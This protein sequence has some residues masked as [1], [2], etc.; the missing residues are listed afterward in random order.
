MFIYDTIPDQ[1]NYQIK[2]ISI[3]SD[4]KNQQENFFQKKVVIKEKLKKKS[5]TKN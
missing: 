1:K 4:K 3:N 5:K 2:F